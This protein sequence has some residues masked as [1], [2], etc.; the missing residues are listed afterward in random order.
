M[1]LLFTSVGRRSYLIQYFR[2]ALSKGDEIHVMNSSAISPA[3]RL[4]DKAV[5]SP[6][7]YDKGYIPFLEDYCVKNSIDAIISL[8]D[9]DLPI[10]AKNKERFEKIGVRVL[11]SESR[12]VNICNDKWLANKFLLE[13]GYNVP[14]T[15][16]D[17]QSALRAVKSG[18]LRFPLY[19][20]PRWG[21]GSIGVCLAENEAELKVLYE[22]VRRDIFNTYLKY[23]SMDDK[24]HCV[25]IQEKLNG[26]EYGLDI[27]NDLNGEYQ[28]TV[29]KKKYAMRSGETDCAETVNDSSLKEL[30]RNIALLL[31]HICNLDVDVFKT[32]NKVYVLEM[33]A[34]FGGGYPFSHI[35]GVDLPLAIVKWLS[36]ES[37][38]GEILKEK[39]GVLSHKDIS[40]VKINN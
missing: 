6:L 28:T 35:A 37:D 25:L 26:Q 3:F 1:N 13:K 36:G 4:A 9:I 29:V 23:E 8:F 7:I 30:G 5:V 20:K 24:D 15:F 31:R 27:I 14:K 39:E 22:K 2:E 11:V 19:L 34:R 40:L 12:V 32:D 33:N 16:I 10:L 17:A 21:M 18:E 38:C